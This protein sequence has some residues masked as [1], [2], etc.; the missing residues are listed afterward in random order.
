MQNITTTVQQFRNAVLE[1]DAPQLRELLADELS[2]GHSDGHV[3]GKN[4][5]ID[6][7]SDGTYSFLTMELTAQTITETGNFAIVRHELDAK[8]NDEGKAGEAHLYVLLV[9]SKAETGWKLIARQAVKKL[10]H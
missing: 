10:S 1:S 6:K 9:W 3:E 7:I 2:Y 5:F 8:T 4:D